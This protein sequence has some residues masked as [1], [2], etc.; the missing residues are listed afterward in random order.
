MRIQTATFGGTKRNQG[1][2][3]MTPAPQ[4]MY[5]KLRRVLERVIAL[6]LLSACVPVLTV[7]AILVRRTSPGPAL[8]RQLRLGH[9]GKPFMICKLRTMEHNCEARTGPVWSAQDDPRVTRIGRLL[10]DTHLDELPQLWNVVR[11]E[12]SLIGPRPERPEI[13]RKIERKLPAYARRL[14]VKPGMTGLAQLLLP[15]DSDLHGVEKKLA[16]DLQYIRRIGLQ[17]DARIGVATVL[18]FLGRALGATSRWLVGSKAAPTARPTLILPP[19]DL[20]APS[21]RFET[22]TGEVV[23]QAAAWSAAA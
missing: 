5:L 17:T 15:P 7:L 23:A 12:M 4:G 11:G 2:F 6:L 10:R 1:G 18:Y 14:C 21:L 13:A 19:A 8:Y 9:N 22:Y 16:Q 20:D 3:F